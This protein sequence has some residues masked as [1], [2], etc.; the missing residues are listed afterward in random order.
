MTR[1]DVFLVNLDPSVGSEIRKARPCVIVSPDE[2][3]RHVNTVM[4][5]PMTTVC[6]QWPT[7]VSVRFGGTDGQVAVDQMRA[8]DKTRLIR[9]LGT[10]NVT[11]SAILISTIQE[12]FA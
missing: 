1:F 6:R 4:I 12:F 2:M 3:N 10:L 9:R 5:A 7:R 8:V 11:E